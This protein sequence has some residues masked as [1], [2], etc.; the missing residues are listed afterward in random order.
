[1]YTVPYA[2][3]DKVVL[4]VLDFLY[5]RP[6]CVFSLP[7]NGELWNFSATLS[8]VAANEHNRQSR[9]IFV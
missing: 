6:C 8:Q 9:D 7:P 1:M 5:C 2:I 3:T 4:V